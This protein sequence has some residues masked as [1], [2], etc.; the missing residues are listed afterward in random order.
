MTSLLN[1]SREKLEA[2]AVLKQRGFDVAGLLKENL[3][4]VNPVWVPN[5]GPQTLGFESEADELFYGGAGGGGKTEL[6]LGCAALNQHRSIIFRRE[7]PSLRG[8]IER[9]R[10]IY[11]S[12]DANHQKDSY[13]ES[14]HT[15]RLLNGKVIEFGSIQYEKDKE[16]Y[17]GHP[18]DFYG[19]GRDYRV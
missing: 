8:I 18:H 15:W 4:K 14:L 7:F 1:L 10:E 17:H 16:K 5:P 9:S 12:G 11:N 13:N 2:L 6:L 19:S 3:A